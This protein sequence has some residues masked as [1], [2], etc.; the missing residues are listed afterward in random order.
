ML[1]AGRLLFP[2]PSH[3][4]DDAAWAI[5]LGVGLILVAWGVLAR[6]GYK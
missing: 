6:L 5:L 1:I 3:G 2:T 4:R